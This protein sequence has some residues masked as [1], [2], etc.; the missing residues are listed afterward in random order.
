MGSPIVCSTLVTKTLIRR[1]IGSS[2][3]CFKIKLYLELNSYVRE[4]FDFIE[5]LS[6]CSKTYLKDRT[7]VQNN[8]DKT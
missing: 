5:V 2:S 7:R 6:Y 3:T 8:D 1:A 4:I